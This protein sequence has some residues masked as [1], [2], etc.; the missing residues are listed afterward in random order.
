[1]L[2]WPDSWIAHDCALNPNPS[3]LAAWLDYPNEADA[4]P[5]GPP[6]EADGL[7]AAPVCDGPPNPGLVADYCDEMALPPP[8]LGYEVGG[9]PREPC[10]DAV[11]DTPPKETELG[12]PK[13]KGTLPLLLLPAFCWAGAP[14]STLGTNEDEDEA[15][16]YAFPGLLVG[17]EVAAPLAAA[18]YPPK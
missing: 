4:A 17:D 12:P 7:A 15:A 14:Q 11:A 16:A 6:K 8:K 10:A 5:P 1:M 9:P 3:E 18:A 13:P 2:C